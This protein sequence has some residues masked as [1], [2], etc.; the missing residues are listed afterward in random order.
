MQRGSASTEDVKQRARHFVQGG[1]TGA[2]IE[3]LTRFGYATRGVVFVLVGLVAARAAIGLGSTAGTRG[4]IRALG[5]QPFGRTLLALTA[6]GLGGYV[7]WRFVQ[8]AFD[9]VYDED[10]ESSTIRRLGFLGSGLFYAALANTTARL[11]LNLGSTGGDM[12]VRW[13]TWAL[14]LPYGAWLVG[15]AGAVLMGVGGHA[16]YR[17]ATARFMRLYPPERRTATR[18]RIG[19]IGLSA[20]GLTLCI[21]GGFVIVAAVYAEPDAVVGIGGALEVLGRGPYGTILLSGT[22]AGFVVYGVHCFVLARHRRI[23]P[24]QVWM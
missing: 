12:R 8:A 14:S 5:R 3:R 16:F 17:V 10:G 1:R 9:P 24:P 23:R 11:A 20:L 15:G 21:I 13:A 18:R 6:C 2:W 4:V 7:L 22:A 19:R